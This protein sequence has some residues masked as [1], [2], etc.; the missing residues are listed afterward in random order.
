MP[1]QQPE[2]PISGAQGLIGYNVDL[3]RASGRAEVSLEI[4]PQHLNRN[5]SL[6]GGILAMMLDCAAGFAA[7]LGFGGD[8]LAQVVT[9][10]LSTQFIAP[11]HDGRVVARGTLSGGGRKIVHADAVLH[12]AEG[13]L[14]AKASG[15]FKRVT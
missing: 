2:F 10:S 11:V 6:H 15:T 8:R 7:S 5:A 14:I 9:V 4:A 13:R 1:S 3:D 12:D